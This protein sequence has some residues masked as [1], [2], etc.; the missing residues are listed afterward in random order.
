MKT[1]WAST[2]A[3]LLAVSAA[4]ALA[5]AGPSDRS[6]MGQLPSL[7]A[8]SLD[9]EAFSVPGK[10][11]AER[12]L[13]LITFR[14]TQ[15]AH[16]DGWVEGLKLHADPS[17]AWVRMPVLNDPGSIAARNAIETRLLRKY[18]APAERARLVPVFTDQ[19]QFIRSA[20]LGG[21]DQAHVVV[22]NR[23]GEVLARVEGAFD[24]NKADKLR[25]TLLERF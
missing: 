22:I 21:P 8:R 2:L 11:P 3:W 5:A 9:Q 24:A 12:T 10:L 17:I 7:T 16:I 18:P 19:T 20:A 1:L 15:R 25:E 13:A 4:V 14:G 6:V 23:D